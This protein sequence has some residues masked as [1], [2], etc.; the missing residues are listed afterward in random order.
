MTAF[1]SPIRNGVDTASLFVA[2]DA[3]ETETAI[4]DFQLLATTA[5]PSRSRP[6]PA[7]ADDRP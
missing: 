7:E 1:A 2:L 4:A 6:T 5:Y 3:L